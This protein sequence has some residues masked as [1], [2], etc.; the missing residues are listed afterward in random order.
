MSY[1]LHMHYFWQINFYLKKC[2]KFFKEKLSQ[3]KKIYSIYC[4]ATAIEMQLKL[5][6]Q[7]QK[8]T[9]ITAEHQ[10]GSKMGKTSITRLICHHKECAIAQ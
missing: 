1:F 6:G 4:F 5:L 3:N 10:R 2:V 8:A 7:L 9:K